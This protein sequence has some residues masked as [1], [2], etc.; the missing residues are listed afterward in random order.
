M[1]ILSLPLCD[2]K[3]LH[4]ISQRGLHDTDHISM[5]SCKKG[6]TRHAYAWQIGPFWQD[7][8]DMGYRYVCIILTCYD[9]I[10]YIYIWYMTLICYNEIWQYMEWKQYPGAYFLFP[11][12][13][14]PFTIM[15]GPF[16]V[17]ICLRIWILLVH[18]ITEFRTWINNYIYIKL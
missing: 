8:L 14:E 9:E 18:F 5:V 6:P 2:S 15:T 13:V 4:V 17:I 3:I 11:Y 7:T 10:M 12:Q 16:L 1:A